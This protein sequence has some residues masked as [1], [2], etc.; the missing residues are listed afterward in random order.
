[1]HARGGAGAGDADRGRRGPGGAG[2]V[3]AHQGRAYDLDA[4]QVRANIE[5][6][7]G[8]DPFK[9]LADFDSSGKRLAELRR[10]EGEYKAALAAFESQFGYNGHFDHE[11]KAIL[12]TLK[13]RF[14]R[15]AEDEGKKLSNADADDLAHADEGYRAW[16]EQKGDERRQ[17][18]RYKAELAAVRAQIEEAILEREVAERA[19]RLQEEMI[20]WGRAEMRL[21]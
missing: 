2:G 13:V 15:E 11:R 4:S 20:R 12:S 3:L 14:Q 21:S 1:M 17:M 16:L 9:A 18:D 6:L 8:V 7:I 10:E 5:A 19:L